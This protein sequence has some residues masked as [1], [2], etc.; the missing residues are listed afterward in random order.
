[1]PIPTPPTEAELRNH[2]VV[3]R[4]ESKAEH[5]R[6]GTGYHFEGE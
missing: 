3:S 5:E 2:P 1:M 6:A 4:E